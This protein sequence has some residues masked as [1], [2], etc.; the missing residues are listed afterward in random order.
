M[1]IWVILATFLA[2]LASY[3]L[4]VRPD[5]RSVTVEPVAEAVLGKIV[6]QHKSAKNYVK[7]HKPPFTSH[8]KKVAY[9]VGV[10]DK[11]ELEKET[12]YGF[13]LSD[14]YTSKIFCMN[15]AFSYAYPHDASNNPCDVVENKRML[16]TYGPSPSRW[17]SL[18]SGLQ[19]PNLDLMNA[20]RSIVNVGE[21]LGYIIPADASEVSV[22]EDN[23]SGSD[24]K[25]I[26]RDGVR[27]NF[28]PKAI[29]DDPDFKSVCDLIKNWG[30]LIYMNNI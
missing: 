25:L 17:M 13:I 2:M 22:S 11:A 20:M 14:D 6:V 30:C 26:D 18:S 19:R 12:P 5:M 24:V 29:V 8:P 27:I 9:Q 23:P 7:Y 15:T 21:K 16:I 4:A 1:Y 10:I 28:V 3:T